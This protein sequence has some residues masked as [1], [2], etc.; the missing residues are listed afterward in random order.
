MGS[1]G[2]DPRRILA[3]GDPLGF[4]SGAKGWDP[5]EVPRDPRRGGTP[6]IPGITYLKDLKT[7]FSNKENQQL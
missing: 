5:V 1:L 7:N 3:S 4:H 2:L 6:G